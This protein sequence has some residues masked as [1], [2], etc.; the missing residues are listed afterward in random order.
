MS[1]TVLEESKRIHKYNLAKSLFF[2]L[3]LD[4][5]FKASTVTQVAIKNQ[6]EHP[7]PSSGM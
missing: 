6:K 4:Y 2:N 7:V 5:E 1:A 3:P